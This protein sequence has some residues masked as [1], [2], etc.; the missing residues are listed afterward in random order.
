MFSLRLA[1]VQVGQG[2]TRDR[3]PGRGMELKYDR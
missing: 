2:Q 3:C 1:V